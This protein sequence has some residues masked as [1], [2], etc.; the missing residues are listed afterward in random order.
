M[1][2]AKPY[3]DIDGNPVSLD[4]LVKMEPEWAASRI[5][6]EIAKADALRAE[7]DS[8]KTAHDR[9]KTEAIKR[10]E[11]LLGHVRRAE[12]ELAAERERVCEAIHQWAGATLAHGAYLLCVEKLQEIRALDLGAA[13]G[14]GDA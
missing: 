11:S 5:R 2:D 12:A 4:A 7:R 10:E 13:K 1:S 14:G 9:A 6:V 8:W 3:Q